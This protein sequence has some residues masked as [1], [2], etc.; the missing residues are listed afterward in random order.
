M[1]TEE[2]ILCHKDTGIPKNLHI[3][4]PGRLGCYV[5]GCGQLCGKCYRDVYGGFIQNKEVVA[6]DKN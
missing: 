3:D 2:C 4:D 6:A 1:E 5:E